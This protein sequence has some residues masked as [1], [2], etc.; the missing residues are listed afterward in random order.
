LTSVIWLKRGLLFSIYLHK[1]KVR[2]LLNETN[3]KDWEIRFLY[4][5]KHGYNSI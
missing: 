5:S 2:N 4:L 3:K 1:P